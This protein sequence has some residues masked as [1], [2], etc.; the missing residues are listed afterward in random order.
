VG[1]RRIP[2]QAVLSSKC[3]HLQ[4]NS[5]RKSEIV[6]STFRQDC[7]SVNNRKEVGGG[8]KTLRELEGRMLVRVGDGL[9]CD[10]G[11]VDQDAVKIVV[12]N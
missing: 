12:R 7:I 1:Q 8:L 3:K 11:D 6:F 10:L 2:L 5:A 9:R 4:K